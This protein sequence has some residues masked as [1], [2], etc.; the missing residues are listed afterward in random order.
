MRP[1]IGE[2]LAV[3]ARCRDLGAL[4]IGIAQPNAMVIAEIELGTV[5][6][7]VSFAD[8]VIRPDDASACGE[9]RRGSYLASLTCCGALPAALSSAM[10]CRK[11]SIP[12]SVKAAT[13]SSPIP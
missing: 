4:H 6:M 5:A 1:P 13:P 11:H 7:Q 10:I 8:M 3:D 2:P 12:Y 9:H